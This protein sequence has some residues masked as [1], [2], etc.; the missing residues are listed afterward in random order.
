MKKLF[1]DKIYKDQILSG[2]KTTTIRRGRRKDFKE[3]DVVE[4][5][6]GKESL[7]LAYIEKIEYKKLR[8]VSREDAISDGFSSRRKLKEAL[9][10]YYKNINSETEVT[11]IYFKRIKRS[12]E[13]V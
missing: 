11:V 4:I 5:I 7:G 12:S 2:R 13:K 1:F 9:K 6:C 10:K 8:D 3:G